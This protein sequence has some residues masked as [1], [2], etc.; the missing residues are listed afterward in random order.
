MEI[1]Q[2]WMDGGCD[3]TF[4][5][6]IYGDLPK[7]NRNLLLMFNKKENNIN[8]AKLLH[9][10]TKVLA[11]PVVIASAK[12]DQI[13][14]RTS[15]VEK[16]ILVAENKQALFF[17][18]LPS[19]LRPVLLEANQLFKENCYLKVE[20][21]ELPQHAEKAAIVLQMQI[22]RNFERNE[23][24]WQKIDYYLEHRVIP[25]AAKSKFEGHS[26]AGLLRTQQLLYASISKLNSRL[27]SN[28]EKLGFAVYV[29]D[30]SKI[31][32]MI[33]KQE[34]NLL[35]QNEKLI[36]ITQIIDGR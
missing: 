21:N 20:L 6:A 23:L 19:E 3:Y 32:R 15:P 2:D 24:C 29:A 25:T 1:I 14:P 16:S 18:Q 31:E 8:K 12:V 9:E 13:T 27:K 26:P 11:A 33:M 35:K 34:Q 22:H 4:G 28:N 7:Y 10:L 36:E 30:K 17:H 5:V